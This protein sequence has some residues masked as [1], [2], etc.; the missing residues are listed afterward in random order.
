MVSVN[1]EKKCLVKSGKDTIKNMPFRYLKINGKV[2]KHTLPFIFRYFAIY[3][4]ILFGGHIPNQPLQREVER[5]L[6]DLSV[7]HLSDD[8]FRNPVY[9][10]R[11]IALSQT[12]AKHPGKGLV[13]T[14]PCLPEESLD[15][16]IGC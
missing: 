8:T 14:G 5:M 6:S 4:D 3:V 7:F 12:G 15:K 11:F 1:E 9:T 2:S 13:Y 10:F 16:I